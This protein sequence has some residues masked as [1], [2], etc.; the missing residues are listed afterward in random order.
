[1][2]ENDIII[3]MVIVFIIMIVFQI[4]KIISVIYCETRFD[5]EFNYLMKTNHRNSKFSKIFF[6]LIFQSPPRLYV[7]D[8]FS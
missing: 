8:D 1:M 2:N 7:A 3:V 6:P 5:E 4:K